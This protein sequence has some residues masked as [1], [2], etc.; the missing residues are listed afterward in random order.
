MKKFF[1]V[2]MLGFTLVSFA[3]DKPIN[4]N[5]VPKDGQKFVNQYFGSKQ[6]GSSMLEDDFFS[7]EYKVY[8]LNGT[9]IE[10]DSDGSW[11]EVDGKRN[12]IPTGFVPAKISTYVKRSFPNTKITKIERE[13]N[14]FEVKLSNGLELKFDENGNFKKIED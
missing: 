8:L 12:P 14:G 11:K 3:Q 13:R 7:K 5:Q 1:S 4:Y 10:F 6:V 2:I 9:K